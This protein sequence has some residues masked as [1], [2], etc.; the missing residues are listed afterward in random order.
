MTSTSNLV[1]L[2]DW[3]TAIS[4]TTH[5]CLISCLSN[6]SF[7]GML[8]DTLRCVK[9]QVRCWGREWGGGACRSSQG[10]HWLHNL[11]VGWSSHNQKGSWPG[12]WVGVRNTPRATARVT[13]VILHK[14]GATPVLVP[15]PL[16]YADQRRWR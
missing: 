9:R 15:I 12:L 16:S 13:H 7:T 5:L 6:L 11:T 4:A 14:Y 3:K 8:N 10:T 2:R 1:N